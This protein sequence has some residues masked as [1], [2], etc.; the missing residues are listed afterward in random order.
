MSENA[1]GNKNRKM[2]NCGGERIEG[3]FETKVLDIY[4]VN[5]RKGL[6]SCEVEKYSLMYVFGEKV[7]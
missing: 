3:S 5:S 4:M 7:V 6:C 2:I 1:P